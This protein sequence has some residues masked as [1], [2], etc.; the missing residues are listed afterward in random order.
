MHT[1]YTYINIYIIYCIKKYNYSLYI[2]LYYSISYY[3][4]L[5]YIYTVHI[6]MWLDLVGGKN[7]TK[8]RHWAFDNLKPPLGCQLPINRIQQD[9]GRWCPHCTR[10][11][12]KA[13]KAPTLAPIDPAALTPHLPPGTGRLEI[14]ALSALW[15][16][17]SFG[18]P[19][20]WHF[21]ER[22]IIQQTNVAV[23]VVLFSS[24]MVS[25]RKNAHTHRYIYI[26]IL[27]TNYIIYIFPWA[28]TQL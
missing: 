19:F 14:T 1:Y 2:I 20:S 11:T 24:V 26:Y 21:R 25:A 7:L 18:I 23:S 8:H 22:I 9:H 12:P 16:P 17:W 28:R 15:N 6:S 27:I 4:I 3:I 5:Y 10:F 13:A